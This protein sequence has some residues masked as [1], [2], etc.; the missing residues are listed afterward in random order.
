ME[1]WVCSHRDS[2]TKPVCMGP[3]T[4]QISIMPA[5]SAPAVMAPDKTESTPMTTAASPER[6]TSA[7]LAAS[8]EPESVPTRAEAMAAAADAPA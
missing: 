3:R 5:I 8:T 4:R 6:V 2:M 7:W 1:A